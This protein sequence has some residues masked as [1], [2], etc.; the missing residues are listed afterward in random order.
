MIYKNGEGMRDF[1][2][3]FAFIVVQF[4]IFWARF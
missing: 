2:G 3:L 4:S 1:L